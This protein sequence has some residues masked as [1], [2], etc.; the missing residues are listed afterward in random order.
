MTIEFMIDAYGTFVPLQPSH[1]LKRAHERNRDA[2]SMAY[3]NIGCN[4]QRSAAT[5]VARF[6]AII[7]PL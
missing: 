2:K 3:F 1:S 6:A 5:A 4:T 7:D